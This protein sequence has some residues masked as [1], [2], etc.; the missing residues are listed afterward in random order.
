MKRGVVVASDVAWAA[1]LM[2]SV[3]AFGVGLAVGLGILL[4]WVKL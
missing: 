3:F 1:V 4:D 2:G